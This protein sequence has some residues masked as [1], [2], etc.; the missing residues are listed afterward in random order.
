MG[1]W[2]RAPSSAFPKRKASQC[3]TPVKGACPKHHTL[4]ELGTE[5]P[6]GPT[7][8]SGQQ[9]AKGVTGVTGATGASGPQ[10]EK[11]ETGATGPKGKQGPAGRGRGDRTT[12]ATGATGATGP[13]AGTRTETPAPPPGETAPPVR[14]EQP[15]PPEQPEAAPTGAAGLKGAGLS[16]VERVQGYIAFA[17]VFP[18]VDETVEESVSCTEGKTLVGGGAVLGGTG[19]AIKSSAPANSG[20]QVNGTWSVTAR[21]LH[22]RQLGVDA[23]CALCEVAGDSAGMVAC[24]SQHG[25]PLGGQ[26]LRRVARSESPQAVFAT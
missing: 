26:A 16:S 2:P 20:S 6:T 7:G 4:T 5:G 10:G 1:R 13:Q 22:L 12:G 18:K 25:P 23:V 19:G 24:A 14:A 15:V 21:R 9:G 11:G 3:L 8:A 17:P